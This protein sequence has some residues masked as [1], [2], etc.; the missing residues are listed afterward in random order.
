MSTPL[1]SSPTNSLDGVTIHHLD[2]E[3]RSEPTE[4]FRYGEGVS[5][6]SYRMINWEGSNYKREIVPRKDTL[7]VSCHRLDFSSD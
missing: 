7:K 4:V 6:G 1:P 2:T 3:L 5:C